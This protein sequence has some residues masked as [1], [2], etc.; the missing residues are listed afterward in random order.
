M[1]DGGVDG[2]AHGDDTGHG[3]WRADADEDM[4]DEDGDEHGHGGENATGNGHGDHDGS[5]HPHGCR[6]FF[7]RFPLSAFLMRR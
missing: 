3:V 5:V 6:V 7:F 1:S 4:L 2:H